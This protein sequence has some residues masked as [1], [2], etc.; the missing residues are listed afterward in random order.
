LVLPGAST[1]RLQLGVRGRVGLGS[2]SDGIKLNN[3]IYS[4]DPFTNE[5]AGYTDLTANF[6]AKQL[7]LEEQI[8]DERARE[9]A[10][11]G[12][13]F[14]DLVRIAKRRN[15]PSFLA[16]KVAAKYHDGRRDQIYNHLLNPDNWYIKYF[17]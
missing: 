7:Y 13:R 5:I 1:T 4:H 6:T 15:D 9:L 11:E 2:A 10:Y 16:K 8:L 17:D 14:Y 12:E 3:I